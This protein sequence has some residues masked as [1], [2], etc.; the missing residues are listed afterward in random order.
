MNSSTMSKSLFL[1]CI[2]ASSSVAFS[3]RTD[4]AGR[5]YIPSCLFKT[6]SVKIAFKQYEEFDFSQEDN[7]KSGQT[8]IVYSDK[9]DNILYR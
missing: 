1:L 9:E 7:S 4:D 5:Y 6:R 3:Q 2:I 8:W